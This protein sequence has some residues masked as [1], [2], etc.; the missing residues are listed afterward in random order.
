MFWILLLSLNSY[1]RIQVQGLC[2]AIIMKSCSFSSGKTFVIF[3]KMKLELFEHAVKK[4]LFYK[5]FPN[6]QKNMFKG[7]NDNKRRIPEVFSD[8]T[9]Y[10]LERVYHGCC[11]VVIVKSAHS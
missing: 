8:L 7:V 4:E 6:S 5:R 9:K 11:V 10:S 2:I 1:T 3:L